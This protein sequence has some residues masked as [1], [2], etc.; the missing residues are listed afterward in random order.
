MS[1][2]ANIVLSDWMFCDPCRNGR[3]NQKQ[4]AQN[5]LI[6][7]VAVKIKGRAGGAPEQADGLF[8]NL[9]RK[10][11]F[12][13]SN[14]VNVDGK[15][16]RMPNGYP[17]MESKGNKNLFVFCF[18]KKFADKATYDPI[19]RLSALRPT[20]NPT[21]VLGTGELNFSLPNV[22][23]AAP[24]TLLTLLLTDTFENTVLRAL[25]NGTCMVLL[26]WWCCGLLLRF[27]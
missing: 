7:A 10:I 21:T 12:V 8:Y 11:P 26:Q 20:S 24:L 22:L 2:S 3:K 18:P 19:I 27:V 14:R 13:L 16:M 5:L 4:P 1:S 15:L 23:T 25:N 17:R 9:D 6:M